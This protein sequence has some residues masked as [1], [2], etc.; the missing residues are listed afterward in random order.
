MLYRE[1]DTAGPDSREPVTM[2]AVPYRLWANR[3]R[4]PMAVWLRRS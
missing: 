1:A 4:G 2:R 3:G